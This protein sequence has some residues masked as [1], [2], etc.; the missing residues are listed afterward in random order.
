MATERITEDNSQSTG[1][2]ATS[3]TG[4]PT[5][6]TYFKVAVT[7]VILTI[8]EVVLFLIEDLGYGII[9]VIALLSIAKFVLVGLFYMHLRFDHKLFATLFGTGL[10]LA[11]G[12]VFALMGLF[13]WFHVS[14]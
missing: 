3:N 2:G 11:I 7:L 13:A 5:P 10:F 1:N 8:L 4:H 6:M 12:V 14:G 9:P